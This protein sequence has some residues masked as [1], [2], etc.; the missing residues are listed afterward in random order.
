MA[1]LKERIKEILIR[2]KII[3]PIEL[4]KALEEQK[5]SKEELSKIL[6]NKKLIAEE[7]LSQ[8]LSES[9]GLPQ[10]NISRLQIDANVVKLIPKALAE[11][12]KLIPVSLMGD[13]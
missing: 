13:N 6:I 4:E 8:I 2:D 7:T 9:L 12:Y 3:D 5:T 1:S 11:K 10:I